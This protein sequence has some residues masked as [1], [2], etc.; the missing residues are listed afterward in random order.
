MKPKSVK[1]VV[2]QTETKFYRE[3][4]IYPFFLTNSAVV[5]QVRQYHSHTSPSGWATP[6]AELPN[7]ALEGNDLAPWLKAMKEIVMV[8]HKMSDGSYGL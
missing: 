3:T 8:F 1:P 7:V 2:T 5:I 6:I 4:L